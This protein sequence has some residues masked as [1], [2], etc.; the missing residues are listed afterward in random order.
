MNVPAPKSV[1]LLRPTL[2]T[3]FHI[4]FNWWQ[5]NDR[6][7]KV[8][9]LSL[10]CE[11]HRQQIENMPEGQM[12]DWVDNE[13]GEVHAVDGVQHLLMTH[14]ALQPSFINIHTALVEAIFR[15]LLANGNRPMTAEELAKRLN[16]PATTIL[17]TLSGPR[18]YKGIRPIL[19]PS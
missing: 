4:D 18:A 10:L 7:W 1:F 6:D 16:R 19:P 2:T 12:L 11:E 8:Y 3:P 9:L 5:Q 15:T 14:C 13:T 17:Q